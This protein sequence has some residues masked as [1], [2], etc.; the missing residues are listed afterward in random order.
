MDALD[1]VLKK[2]AKDLVAHRILDGKL[3]TREYKFNHNVP[4]ILIYYFPKN[5][6]NSN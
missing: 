6:E 2:F 1:W 5:P 3:N 4:Y